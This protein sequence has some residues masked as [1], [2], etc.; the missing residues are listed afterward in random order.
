MGG[1]GRRR[2]RRRGKGLFDFLEWVG[3]EKG[4]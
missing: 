1:G 3:L 4:C 2:R